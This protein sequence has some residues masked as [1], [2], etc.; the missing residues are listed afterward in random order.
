[1]GGGGGWVRNTDKQ[2][3]RLRTFQNNA[4]KCVEIKPET[5]NTLALKK[6]HCL[7]VH[8]CISLR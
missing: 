5:H 8:C 2:V 3:T 1:M 4:A 7:P 6:L